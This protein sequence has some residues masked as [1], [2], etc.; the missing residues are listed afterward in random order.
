MHATGWVNR[1]P[2]TKFDSWT[3]FMNGKTFKGVYRP[4]RTPSSADRDLFKAMGRNIA[5][6]NIKYNV[7]Y[8]VMYDTSSAGTWVDNWEITS[9]R[10]D[11]VVEYVY[12]WYGFSVYGSDVTKNDYWI[13]DAHS[14]TAI[15]PQKQVNYLT[16]VKSSEPY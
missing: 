12:E 14:G 6:Q 3:N 11:G 7:A 1:R 5:R 4:Q 8:Q 16:L 15:T 13:R 10:C 9:M 2:H